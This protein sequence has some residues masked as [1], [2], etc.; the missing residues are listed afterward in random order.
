MI[1]LKKASEFDPFEN[2][3]SWWPPKENFASQH[4]ISVEKYYEFKELIVRRSSETVIER[5]FSENRNILALTIFLFSTGH[6][7]TWIY[8]KQTIR[9]SSGPTGGLIPDYILAGA[10][11]DGLSWWV[12]EVK[13]ANQNAFKTEKKRVYLS[14][15]ANKGV[16]QLMNYIDQ[17]SK[18]Q[19]YLRDELKLYGFREPRGVLL[20]G[21]DE[22]SDNEQIREF[23]GAW[24]RINP[25]V[26]IR[27]YSSIVKMLE[28]KLENQINRNQQ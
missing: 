5:F 15:E 17:S 4:G 25:R 3:P 20:I 9:P 10:N 27:S 13:G 8:P 19:C 22:E 12:L 28:K 16:C 26:Q 2:P 14:N 1:T 6:H 7:A 23:K 21:T 24:N 18:T 11:S